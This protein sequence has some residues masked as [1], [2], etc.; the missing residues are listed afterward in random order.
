MSMT[1]SAT[2]PHVSALLALVIPF[3]ELQIHKKIYSP[4][5]TKDL[6]MKLKFFSQLVKLLFHNKNLTKNNYIYMSKEQLKELLF[7]TKKSL[8]MTY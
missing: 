1:F 6:L 8:S 4:N 5:E 7:I 3:T 2:V